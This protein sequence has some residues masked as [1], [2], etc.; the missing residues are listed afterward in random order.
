MF[1]SRQDTNRWSQFNLLE[2]LLGLYSMQN[3]VVGGALHP[4]SEVF[5]FPDLTRI[6]IHHLGRP[7][8]EKELTIKGSLPDLWLRDGDVIE[9]PEK[10]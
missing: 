5:V 6:I 9:V 2:T 4:A 10:P 8:E 1:V 3:V 7:A